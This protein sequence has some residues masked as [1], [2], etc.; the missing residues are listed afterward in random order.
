[1]ISKITTVFKRWRKRLDDIQYQDGYDWARKT[2]FDGRLPIKELLDAAIPVTCAFD[3][4]VLQAVIDIE[5]NKA[6][7]MNTNL[8]GEPVGV[9]FM[10]EFNPGQQ[11]KIHRFGPGS[12]VP[13]YDFVDDEPIELYTADPDLA[14]I[15]TLRRRREEG[16]P[17]IRLIGSD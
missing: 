15:E 17:I 6:A 8:V 2:Y 14:A 13:P 11:H 9:P 10:V 1:M 7:R 12:E 16:M 3:R 5:R 4:G